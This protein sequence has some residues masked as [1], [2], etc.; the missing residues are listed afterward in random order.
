MARF[1]LATYV[2][3]QQ[4]IN[5]FWSEYPDGR[6]VTLLLSDP[7]QFDRVVV[8]AEVY[9]H[10][11]HPH[12]DAAD[13]AAE[14]RG[15]NVKDGANLTS[16]HEN[17]ATSAI[18]RALA[19]MGYAKSREDRPSRQEMAKA[20]RGQDILAEYRR[21]IAAASSVE[22][23]QAFG[24]EMASAGVGSEELRRLYHEKGQSFGAGA[25]KR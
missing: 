14:E 4:R 13:L 23:L 21:R 5:R 3:V 24:Q 22:E 2:D 17:A 6:I 7:A 1:N 19:N 8:R 11:D 18:G 16:W 9:K 12:P 15:Q 20:E 10:R 25:G